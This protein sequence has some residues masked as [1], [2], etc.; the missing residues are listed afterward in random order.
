MTR[1]TPQKNRLPGRVLLRPLREHE[2]AHLAVPYIHHHT[3]PWDTHATNSLM[4]WDLRLP[5]RQNSL[6]CLCPL[7]DCQ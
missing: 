2:D 1:I 6:A 4:S 3:G 5:A 7:P